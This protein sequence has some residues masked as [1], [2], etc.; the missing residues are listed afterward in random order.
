MKKRTARALLFPG[1]ILGICVAGYVALAVYY[2]DGFSFNTWINGVYCTGKTVEEVNKELLEGWEPPVFT[3]VDGEGKAYE[4]SLSEAGY[5]ADF[6]EPLSQY[7][8]KQ[9]PFLWA[10]NFLPGKLP[11]GSFS[12]D[13]P[14]HPHA[15]ISRELLERVWQELPFVKEEKSRERT[16]RIQLTEEGY[17]LIDGLSGRLDMEAGFQAMSLAAAEGDTSLN[18]ADSG[19]YVDIAPDADQQAVLELWEKIDRFQN[20]GIVYDM[21]D[22]QVPVD[23]SVT[24]QFLSVREDGSM[25]LDENGEL[26]LRKEGIEEFINDLAEEYN[27]YGK[28]RQFTATRGDVI[29]VKGGTYGTRLDEAAETAY[30]TQA[31]LEKRSE[32]HVPEYRQEG[33]T[34][35]KDDI[36][37]TYIE[38][39]MTEQKLYYYQDGE[40]LVETSVVTGNLSNHKTPAGV[41]YVYSKQTNRVLRGPGYASPVKYWMPVKG[42]IGIHD[43]DWRSEFGGEIYKKNGSHG[44]INVPK[45]VMGGLYDNVELGTP[46]IMFY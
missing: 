24:W 35:G 41:N 8:E 15:D 43:A 11:A 44:C 33:F 23:A 14:L 28:E 34:R 38:V 3:V 32:I 22:K 42:G 37:D 36:G 2:S 26:L 27:T 19:C 10:A 13:S 7:M 40:C 29:A 21:G 6:T 1:L 12:G 25:L 46:V 30:L 31:F 16:L 18:L 17:Q 20:T 4:I 9:N 5:T 39:D 45:E